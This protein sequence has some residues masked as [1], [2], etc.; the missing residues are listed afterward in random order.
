VVAFLASGR[1]AY[2]TGSVVRVDGG[3]IAG[4]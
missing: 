4:I 1:A 2:I 3:M